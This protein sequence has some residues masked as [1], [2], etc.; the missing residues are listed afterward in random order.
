MMPWRAIV[1]VVTMI[2]IVAT[3]SMAAD[4][5]GVQEHP[6]IKRYPGQDI[7]WQQIENH[8]PYRI[9]VGPVTGFREIDAWIDTQGRVTRTLYVLRGTERTYSEIYQNYLDALKGE[10]FEF[11]PRA[12]P[13]T[14]AETMSGQPT[15]P[16]SI[17]PNPPASPA[18]SRR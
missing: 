3:V 6:M 10:A 18:R 2:C 11:L 1:A 13:T 14:A 15:G 5:K 8:L 16:V 4:I 7:R 17:L 9:P 12:S